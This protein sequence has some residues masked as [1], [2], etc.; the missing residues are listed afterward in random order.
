MI[1]IRAYSCFKFRLCKFLSIAITCL[2]LLRAIAVSQRKCDTDQ[3]CY[4]KYPNAEP[5]SMTCFGGY[6]RSLTR[7]GPRAVLS[8]EQD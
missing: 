2:F 8:L 7:D 6:C 4:K 3:E 5:G 1:Q